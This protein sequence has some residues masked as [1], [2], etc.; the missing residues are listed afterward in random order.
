MG[1]QSTGVEWDGVGIKKEDHKQNVDCAKR[2]VEW[3][4]RRPPDPTA[5]AHSPLT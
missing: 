4:E 5:T 2:N 1:H 3:T